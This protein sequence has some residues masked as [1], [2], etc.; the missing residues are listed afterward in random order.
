M[1]I[2]HCSFKNISRSEGRSA[3]AAAAY[4]SGEKLTNLYDGV[5]HDY[6]K[7]GWIAHTEIML[8][9]NAPAGY[10]DRETLWN[11]VETVEKSADCRL[12]RECEL[13]LPREMTL[14]QQIELVQNYV[15]DQFVSLGMCAD[16]AIHNPPVHDD[17][18]R[19]LDAFGK[20]TKDRAK[21]QFQNPHAHILLT[22][23]P[24]DK[25]GKWEPKSQIVYRCKCGSQERGFTAL[26]F[27]SAALTGWEKQY[28]YPIG[29]EKV[30]LTK[31]EAT[32]RGL[33]AIADR[34]NKM[35]RTIVHGR[36]N[37]KTAYWN[38]TLRIEEW[39][40]AW[41]DAVNQKFHE[42]HMDIHIDS[43]SYR[44]QGRAEIPSIH[45]GAR[46]TNLSRR[47][48]RLQ[49]K[50]SDIGE[51]NRY[52]HTYN[53]LVRD[54]QQITNAADKKVKA[55]AKHLE[56][57]R[58][59]IIRSKYDLSALSKAISA[60]QQIKGQQ[61]DE[62]QRIESTID[63]TIALNQA[64]LQLMQTL[65]KAIESCGR[66]QIK[67]KA[68]LQQQID[69][70]RQKQSDRTEYMQT[71]LRQREYVKAEKP[72]QEQDIERHS[73]RFAGV[74]AELDAFQKAYEAKLQK[75]P[76]SFAEAIKTERMQVRAQMEQTCKQQLQETYC[77][78]FHLREYNSCVRA[79]DQQ[80]HDENKHI[81]HKTKKKSVK[82][83]S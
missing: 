76:D 21:M 25:N 49:Q 83:R 51:I 81:E 19:P 32:A 45:M 64:S 75:I 69:L 37:P 68:E 65:E 2:Y 53:Q 30:W 54:D 20:P 8:P 35:P 5:T 79:T 56:K 36:E 59:N 11:A 6:T 13:A 27:R 14:Q 60:A 66:F 7:K 47:A 34:I 72:D 58:G 1:A 70:E 31:S 67:K 22:V 9:A 57:L 74:Q 16:I 23:R 52:I 55:A 50:D 48:K 3:V 46:A 71:L 18:G 82:Y 24:I 43:R 29:N 39:R 4:R 10:S 62:L 42:L 77:G 38:S 41:E 40:K 28:R 44:A 15:R 26:E 73:A 12:A 33:D 61:Q 17:L 80:L 63:F 78:E